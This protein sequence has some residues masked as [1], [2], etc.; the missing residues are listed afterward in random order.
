MKKKAFI[1]FG[2]VGIL[3]IAIVT[4]YLSY[5]REHMNKKNY[6]KPYTFNQH[7]LSNGMEVLLV[8]EDSLPSLSFDIMFKTGP[9]PVGKEGLLYLLAEMIDKGTKKL[10]AEE[11]TE[12]LEILGAGFYYHL[13]RDVL[14]FSTGT[15]PHLHA[16]LLKIFSAII[17]LPALSKEEF[18]RAKEK[19][20]GYAQRSPENFSFYASRVFNKYLYKSHPY[21]SYTYGSVSSLKALKLKDIKDFYSSQFHPNKAILTVAGRY[22]EDIIPKLEKVFGSWNKKTIVQKK[23]PAEIPQIEKAKLLIVDQPSAVQS[24]IRMGHISVKRSHPDFLALMAGNVILGRSSSSR[25]YVRLRERKGL[26]YHVSSAFSAKRDLGAFKTGMAVRNNKTGSALL[27]IIGVIEDFHK[28]GL[29]SEELKKAKKLLKNSFITQVSTAEKFASFLLYLASQGIPYTYAEEYFH[30][31]SDLN[32]RQV[33]QA[34]KKH[35][36]PDKLT[37]LLLSNAEQIKSQ[38]R[39][40]EPFTVQSYKDFL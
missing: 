5:G 11:V 7:K 30:Q 12:G 15:L 21:G 38:L 10:S 19:A 33:N 39:D 25:L 36:H 27:E 14:S 22:P 1:L 37:I 9:D 31:L 28:N 18:Q 2:F 17:K 8:K 34:I 20:I 6:Y 32:V 3:T 23:E 29:T 40:F 4:L 24:E 35:L 13:D 26:T 16:D